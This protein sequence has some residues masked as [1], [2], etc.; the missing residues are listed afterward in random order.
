MQVRHL[1]PILNVSDL[2][3]SV[4]WFE[5]LGWKKTWDWGT[6]PTFGGVASGHFEIFLCLDGQGGRGASGH[7]ATFGPGRTRPPR[8]AC[9]CRSGSTTSMPCTGTASNTA[10]R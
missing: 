6:P 1:T 9:G 10:S 3:Q 2:P 8:K 5:A 4:A 7:A